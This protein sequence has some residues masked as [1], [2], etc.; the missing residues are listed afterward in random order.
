[1]K[2]EHENEPKCPHCDYVLEDYWEHTDLFDDNDETEIECQSCEKTFLVETHISRHF[3]SRKGWCSE[4]EGHEWG[5]GKSSKIEQW[6]CDRWNKEGFLQRRDW[7]P[8]ATWERSCV[9][10]DATERFYRGDSCDL[11][12]DSTDPWEKA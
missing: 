5:K 6:L 7:A 9:K 12:I 10:C 8:H 3:T 1:M 2:H 11:P 4:E